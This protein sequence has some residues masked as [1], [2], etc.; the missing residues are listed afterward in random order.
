MLHDLKIYTSHIDDFMYVRRS[1]DAI[2]D[3]KPLEVSSRAG[4]ITSG[5]GT[6]SKGRAHSESKH[7][8]P[9]ACIPFIG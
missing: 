3:A 5:S 2:A 8:V 7:P 1:I 4:S 6:D 9:S